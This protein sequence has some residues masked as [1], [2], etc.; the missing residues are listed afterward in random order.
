MMENIKQRFKGF[1]LSFICLSCILGMGPYLTL[2][3]A[4]ALGTLLTML[5]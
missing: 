4:P 2:Q 1:L 5:P 3:T